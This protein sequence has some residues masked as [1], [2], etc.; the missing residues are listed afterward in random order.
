MKLS[1]I[2]R[3]FEAGERILT[4]GG[5]CRELFVIRKGAVRIEKNRPERLGPGELFGELGA[6][7]GCPE[8]F[9]AVAES[10]VTALALDAERLTA[11]CAEPGEFSLRLIRHLARVLEAALDDPDL[12]AGNSPLLEAPELRR[13]AAAIL[14]RA[15]P[16]TDAH[17]PLP[18]AADLQD[19]ATAVELPLEETYR[20]VQLLFEARYLRLIGGRLS[21]PDP[22]GLRSLCAESASKG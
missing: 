21:L 10:E 9:G 19:L 7:R 20:L 11:L 14:E 17:S 8:P 12:R 1:D 13:V 5:F 18:A 2:E 6:I 15:G 3:K 4:K 22:A 16:A